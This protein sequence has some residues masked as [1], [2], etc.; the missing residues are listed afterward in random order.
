ME[1]IV[2]RDGGEIVDTDVRNYGIVISMRK[3]RVGFE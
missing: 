1:G 2:H 3:K